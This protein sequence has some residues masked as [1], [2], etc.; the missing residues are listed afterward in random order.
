MKP[1]LKKLKLKSPCIIVM[2]DVV[3]LNNK[4]NWYERNPFLV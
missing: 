1:K 2:G 4:L 3:E